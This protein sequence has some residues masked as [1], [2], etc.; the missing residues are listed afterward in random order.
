M[1]DPLQYMF[2]KGEN[3]KE[4]DDKRSNFGRKQEE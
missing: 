4:V 2:I 1:Y 3:R